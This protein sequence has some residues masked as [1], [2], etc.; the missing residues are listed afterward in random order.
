M[1]PGGID[2]DWMRIFKAFPDRFFLGGDQFFVPPALAEAGGPAMRFA[3]VAEGV[4]S[5]ANRFLSLLPEDLA[6]KIGYE[7]AVRVYKIK[8]TS[9]IAGQ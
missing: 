8:D 2:S 5:R 6:R 7:N 4:R 3:K 1:G 9:R